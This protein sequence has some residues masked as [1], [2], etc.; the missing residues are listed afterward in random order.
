LVRIVESLDIIRVGR[1]P[2]TAT[3]RRAKEEVETAIGAADWPFG[4]GMF[5]LN[6]EHGIDKQGRLDRHPNGV[7]PIKIPMI[8]YLELCGWQTEAL[9]A[10]PVGS[11]GRDVL[12]TG[13]LDALLLDRDRYVG[14]EWET[15]N[16]A[17]SHRAINK[18]LDGITRTTLQGGILVLPVRS[19]QRYLTDRV[20]NF[21]EIAPYFE[22]WARYP[23][24]AGALRIYGV[25]HDA[26]NPSVPH[27]PK[28]KAGR[29]L[30]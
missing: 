16:V 28:G 22:F 10:L 6:P 19:M 1:F 21:E 2:R 12:S 18:L 23:V 27:I 5:S 11:E 7:Q 24:L 25:A 4:S 26:L 3:W 8:K 13:D 14:F 20:G 30:G 9:P 15:G 29:A 17:S